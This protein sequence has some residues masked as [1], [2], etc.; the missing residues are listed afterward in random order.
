MT[1]AK[2]SILDSLEKVQFFEKTF[3]LADINMK[4]ILRMY[5]LSFDNTDIGFTQ[6]RKLTW[7]F[8]TITRVLS[9]ICQVK[10]I[11]KK[12]FV[13]MALDKGFET[14]VVYIATLKVMLIYFLRAF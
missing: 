2:L 1:S 10:L 6:L 12:K 4:M 8:F 3:L 9:I 14:F 5:F 11:D 13:N 7:R